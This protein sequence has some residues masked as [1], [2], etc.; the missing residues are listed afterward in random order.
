M[1]ASPFV[2]S[3]P[4]DPSQTLTTRGGPYRVTPGRGIIDAAGNLIAHA[5]ARSAVTRDGG[6]FENRGADGIAPHEA[7]GNAHALAAMMNAAENVHALVDA[8]NCYRRTVAH[9]QRNTNAEE[10]ETHGD[11]AALESRALAAL[12]PF[13][14]QKV[15]P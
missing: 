5:H 11:W 13:E 7:D 6:A 9:L 14:P 12:A 15:A 4:A 3:M 8:L 10:W 2:Y 1:N